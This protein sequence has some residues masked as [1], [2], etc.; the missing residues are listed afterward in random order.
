[1]VNKNNIIWERKQHTTTKRE[2][3]TQSVKEQIAV[4]IIRKSG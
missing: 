3:Q 1:M 4:G 2:S